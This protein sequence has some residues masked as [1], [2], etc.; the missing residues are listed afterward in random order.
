MHLA[1]IRQNHVTV[2]ELE[3]KKLMNRR[4]W[5]MN[6]AQVFRDG[7]LLRAQR[8]GEHNISIPEFLFNS[9]ITVTMRDVHV[10]EVSAEAV[11]KPGGESPQ[12]KAVMN[13]HQQ[14]HHSANERGVQGLRGEPRA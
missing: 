14:F 11:N 9:V 8:D 6:P 1:G 7:E 13:N 4:T 3:K 10:G 5:S 12:F 2:D